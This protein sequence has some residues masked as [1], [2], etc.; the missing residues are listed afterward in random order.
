MAFISQGV[1]LPIEHVEA[2][3]DKLEK[4][5]TF[6]YRYQDKAINWA[7]PVTVDNTPHQITFSTGERINAA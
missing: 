6:I 7:Y 5:K 4:I 3:V 2:V 1:N